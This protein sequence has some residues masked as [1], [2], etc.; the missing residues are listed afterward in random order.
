MFL[1]LTQGR[2]SEIPGGEVNATI[3]LAK[4]LYSQSHDVSIMGSGFASVQTNHL[5]KN[6][7]AQLQ[8]NK[9]KKVK[10]LNP[11]YVIYMFSRLFMSLLW[12][13]KI[14]SINSKTP[15][16][17]IHAQDTGYSGLAAVLAGKILRIPIILTSHGIRHK[18]LEPILC[19]KFNKL[20]LKFEYRLDIFT[21]KKA[22]CV[23]GV[24][25][26]I[27]NYYEKLTKNKIEY[28]PNTIKVKNFEFSETNRELIRNEFKLEKKIKVI[29]FIGRF[30]LEKNLI[31]LLNSFFE[32]SK[33]NSLKLMLVGTG[34]D[35]PRLREF[36]N[37]KNIKDKVIFCGFRHNISEI[38]SAIDIFV[39]PSYT[40]GLSTALLEAMGTSRAIICSKIP[41]HLYLLEHDKE[42]LLV[43]PYRPEE[44]KDAIQSLCNDDSLREKL[45]NNAKIKAQQYD[46]E[47]VFP[48][49]LQLYKRILAKKKQV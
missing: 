33:K 3:S 39:L 16:K 15:I 36:V 49:I 2:I 26:I 34:I 9:K 7:N 27:K 31:T 46:E 21:I 37:E 40:E 41:A 19:G 23:I 38:L 29:G 24:N 18:T 4:W 28:I 8:K 12:M 32:A 30:S 42:A 47:L 10:V 20:I 14:F 11:P 17:L 44:L 13:L 35:E 22:D 1:I 5:S 25:P 45:G 43:D 6:N 48:K